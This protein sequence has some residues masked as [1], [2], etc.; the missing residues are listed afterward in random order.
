M[1][2]SYEEAAKWF[3]KAANQDQLDAVS[4]IAN[5]YLYG[6]GVVKSYNK[7]VSWYSLAVALGD[8]SAQGNLNYAQAQAREANRRF[9]EAEEIARKAKMYSDAGNY[10]KASRLYKKAIKR[11]KK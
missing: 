3:T 8:T 10:D 6:Y 7:A 11:L 4:N 2:Q 5:C 9:D 1:T